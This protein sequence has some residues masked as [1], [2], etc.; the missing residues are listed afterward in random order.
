MG[1]NMATQINRTQEIISRLQ[2]EG[3]VTKLNTASDVAMIAAFS[4][5]METSRREYQIK[6]IRTQ[7]SAA[8]VILNS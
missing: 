4:K 5:R 2:S 3:K 8:Q 7:H 1:F 6:E